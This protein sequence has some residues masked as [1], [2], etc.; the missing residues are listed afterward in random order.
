MKYYTST[1]EFNCGIDL[2]ARQMYIC[3][4][5]RQGKILVHTNIKDND[6]A[7]FLNRILSYCR[8]VRGT[9]A[10]AGKIKGLKGS[11]L[12]N[13][14]LRWAFG[15]AAVI[16]KRDSSLLGPLSK[17]LESRMGGN[18][19]KAN[20]VLAIKMARAVYFMLRNKTAFDP[21]RLTTAFNN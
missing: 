7:Y 9:V 14:Y 8:L 3:L 20:T 2:H 18:K 11:K 13:A 16:A 12:G 10:S 5:D 21:E 6:F 19:F 17:H 1:T 15:E 4:T